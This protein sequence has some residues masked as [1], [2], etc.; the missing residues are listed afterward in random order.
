M[1]LKATIQSGGGESEEE[2]VER[3]S[4][5]G[6]LEGGFTSPFCACAD[7]RYLWFLPDFN[8]GTPGIVSLEY[9]RTDSSGTDA[10]EKSVLP[11][12][13]STWV[14]GI[15]RNASRGSCVL[16]SRRLR[17]LA[18]VRV[19]HALPHGH[20]IAPSLCPRLVTARPNRLD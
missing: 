9:L 4:G 11:S 2:E 5:K 10:P 8:A 19:A 7:S 20:A 12:F 13:H 6:N 17:S 3:N 1:A 15:I 18:A 16:I 14:V